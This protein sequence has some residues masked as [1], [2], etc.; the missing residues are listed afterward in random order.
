MK[1]LYLFVLSFVAMSSN[2]NILITE[3]I[4]GSSYNKAIEISNLGDSNVELGAEGYTLTIYSNGSTDPTA[5]MNLSGILPP[6]SSLVLFNGGLT[7]AD[8]FAAPLGMMDNGVIKHNG[9][10]A[11][12]LKKGETIIDSFG[13]QGV[14]P[15]G[16]WGSSSDNSKDH[17]LRRV[18][19]VV[20]GDTSPTDAFDPST[21]DWQFLAKDT[22]DGLGCIGVD[23]CTGSEPKPLQEGDEPP[24][25]TCIFTTCDEVPLVKL[26]TDFLDDIY[27]GNAYAALESDTTAFRSALHTDIKAG[28]TQLTYNQVWTALITTDEDPIDSDNVILLYTGKSIPKTQNA[29]VSN[30]AP[31]SWNREHVWSKSHGFPDRAQL[32]YTDIHHLRP[33]DASIN[34]LRSNYDFNDGGI[35]AEDGTIVT[36]NNILSGISW[37]PRAA[38]KGDVARMMFYM[39]VRYEDGSDANMPNL[40]LVD[41]VETDGAEFGKL[42]SLY[43]WHLDDSV[44]VVEENRN[45]SIYEFQGNRNPFIDHPD[46]VELIFADQCTDT[47]IVL[48]TVNVDSVSVVEQQTATLT[49]GVNVEGLSY[50]WT[51]MSGPEVSITGG[52]TAVITFQAPDVTADTT[53][54]FSVTVTDAEGNSA[55][56]TSTVTVTNFDEEVLPVEEDSSGG[57]FNFLILSILGLLALRRNK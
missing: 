14:R 52:S 54:S 31:D 30:N 26:R 17:T 6:N 7:N 50:I 15:D 9:D 36:D 51:Q 44:D 12:I 3:Y 45:H 20:A 5:T 29:S 28:H 40:K 13:Q 11:Y 42:C 35:P 24:V 47:P 2:A 22:F 43:Q 8:S 25:N 55:T 46:W 16:Y 34:S 23:A 33:A 32:G 18:G 41:H 19:A 27:Y 1:K 4:E 48:P 10:D 56:A 49:A 37:E 21:G 38:V 53:L 57:S 39:A